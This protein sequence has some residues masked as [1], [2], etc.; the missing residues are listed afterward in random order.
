MGCVPLDKMLNLLFP[1]EEGGR[2][3]VP[4]VIIAVVVFGAGN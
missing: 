4:F 3:S 2:C 1:F